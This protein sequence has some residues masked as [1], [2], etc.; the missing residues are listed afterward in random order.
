MNRE[1]REGTGHDREDRRRS[2]KQDVSCAS[3]KCEQISQGKIVFVA[4]ERS[5]CVSH[6]GGRE[7]IVRG[8]IH[9]VTMLR[10]R[11]F[12]SVVAFV[13]YFRIEKKT[14]GEHREASSGS[15]YHATQSHRKGASPVKTSIETRLLREKALETEQNRKR[16]PRSWKLR[17]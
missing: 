17:R 10:W 15:M 9:Y 7:N 2:P 16:F 14:Q 11:P 6:G 5:M 12:L 13:I 8:G 4:G 3:S 1:L